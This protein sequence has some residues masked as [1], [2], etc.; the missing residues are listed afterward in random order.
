MVGGCGLPKFC[1]EAGEYGSFKD[2]LSWLFS[3]LWQLGDFDPVVGGLKK[4]AGKLRILMGFCNG[5]SVPGAFRATANMVSK[6]ESESARMC[7]TG[8]TLLCSPS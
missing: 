2:V 4:E 3:L 6:M 7:T 5:I 8:P 1:M